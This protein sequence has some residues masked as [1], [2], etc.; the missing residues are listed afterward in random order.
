MAKKQSASPLK[1][2]KNVKIQVVKPVKNKLSKAERD[3]Q[4]ALRLQP[5]ED[6][7]KW[8]QRRGFYNR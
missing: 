8:M 1:N 3:E 7:H 5:G 6:L 4:A 2:S